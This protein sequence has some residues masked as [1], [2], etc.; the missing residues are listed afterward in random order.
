MSARK[1]QQDR[2]IIDSL[3]RALR[4]ISYWIGYK[5]EKYWSHEIPE[6]AIVAEMRGTLM[7]AFGRDAKVRC[8]VPYSEIGGPQIKVAPNGRPPQADIGIFTLNRL[9]SPKPL[10]VIEVKRGH[11]KGSIESDITKLAKLSNKTQCSFRRFIVLISEGRTPGFAL[12]K[13]RSRRARG[14]IDFKVNGVSVSA[15]RTFK[16]IG[17]MEEKSKRKRPKH[18]AQHWVTLFEVR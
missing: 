8:E 16:A 15:R 5:R 7:L 3:S 11:S 12:T 13:T 14:A 2:S 9:H 4:P 18:Q 10:A 1:H 17:S 6:G